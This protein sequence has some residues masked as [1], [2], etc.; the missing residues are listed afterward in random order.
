MNTVRKILLPVI[1]IFS[2]IACNY[3]KSN[4][5]QNTTIEKDPINSNDSEQGITEIDVVEALSHNR[6]LFL[7][8]I[9]QDIKYVK[10]KTKIEDYIHPIF[11]VRICCN[12]IF[13]QGLYNLLVFDLDGNFIRQI[14]QSG[15]GPGEYIQINDFA[16]DET[17]RTIYIYSGRTH[18]VLKY[19]FDGNFIEK[20]FDYSLA[21]NMDFIKGKLLFSGYGITSGYMFPGISQYAIVGDDGAILEKKSLPIYNIKNYIKKQLNYPG[22]NRNTIYGNSILLS[23]PGE[24]TIY[25]VSDDLKIRAKYVLN[26]GKKRLKDEDRYP[27]ARNYYDRSNNIYAF[28]SPFETKNH[29]WQ[30]VV[31]EYAP[32]ILLYNKMTGETFTQ[33]YMGKERINS[34][35]ASAAA[36]MS[37]FGIINNYDGGGIF[38][39]NFPQ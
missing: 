10:L 14:G 34:G 22:N 23:G 30:R 25:S 39:R 35:R 6:D 32:Y 37:G 9:V 8:D 33:R 31:Y 27:S 24:D 20:V 21:D 26:C 17:T 38:F 16:I 4:N 13:V 3:S 11:N 18:D 7:S 15:K 12:N 36:F 28:G 2:I 19:S 5:S 1:I 29:I